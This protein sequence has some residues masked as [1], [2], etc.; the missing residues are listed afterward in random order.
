MPCRIENAYRFA[1]VVLGA[2]ETG[3]RAAV[4]TLM[5][6]VV[7]GVGKLDNDDFSA[8]VMRDYTCRFRVPLRHAYRVPALP[9]E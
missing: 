4:G 7:Y 8:A 1:F 5:G 9:A 6:N 2:G 3:Q